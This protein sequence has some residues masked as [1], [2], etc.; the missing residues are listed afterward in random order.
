VGKNTAFLWRHRFLKAMASHQAVREEGIVEVD[1]TF[2]LES[3]KGQRGLPRPA[4]H[5]GGKGR[6]RGTGPDYIPVMVVQDRAGHLADFQL[7][8][9][10]ARAVKAVLEPLIAPDAVLCSDGAGVYA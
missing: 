3:F 8:Q 4:R 7:E 5:R 2:F 9:L 10:N 6:T 1:E